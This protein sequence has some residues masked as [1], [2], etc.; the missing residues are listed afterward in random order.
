MVNKHEPA[1]IE[2]DEADESEDDAEAIADILLGERERT[3]LHRER[4]AY[5]QDNWQKIMTII[6]RNLLPLLYSIDWLTGELK[7][8]TISPF[9]TRPNALV[10]HQDHAH[11]HHQQ[12][13][14]QHQLIETP[15]REGHHSARGSLSLIDISPVRPSHPP[16]MSNQDVYR[17]IVAFLLP[18]PRSP[19]Q[20]EI[21]S[22]SNYNNEDKE[23]DRMNGIP[24]TKMLPSINLSVLQSHFMMPNRPRDF[25]IFDPV[26]IS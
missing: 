19:Q 14:Q 16:S 20:E 18:L 4:A 8:R 26:S 1:E 24:S 2:E 9:P 15:I 6:I 17:S 22:T 10:A 11:H 12:Q 23:K 3:S 25:R 13:Q 5:Q 21:H 7:S